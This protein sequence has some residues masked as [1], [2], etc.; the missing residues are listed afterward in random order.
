M[1]VWLQAWSWWEAILKAQITVES[2]QKKEAEPFILSLWGRL[3][4]LL[5]QACTD[6]SNSTSPI[7]TVV[8]IGEKSQIRTNRRRD[9]SLLG[10]ACMHLGFAAM[11]HHIRQLLKKSLAT[12]P[13]PTASSRQDMLPNNHE[14]SSVCSRQK[15]QA[16]LHRCLLSSGSAP[17]TRLTQQISADCTERIPQGS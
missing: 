15:Y 1:L 8:K 13:M 7:L 17:A 14:S 2:P 11:L 9:R 16:G 4:T 12:H 6:E 10:D 5:Q 3:G